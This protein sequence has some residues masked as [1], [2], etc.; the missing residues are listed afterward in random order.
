MA[1]LATLEADLER[2]KAARRGG[3][4]L[5]RFRGPNSEREV[6][7]KSD[8][9]MAAAIS[10]TESQIAAMTGAPVI[11]TINVRSKGWS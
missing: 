6:Q 4:R 9:D 2:L 10:A 7:Y 8:A 11:R 5:V 1:D 3:E